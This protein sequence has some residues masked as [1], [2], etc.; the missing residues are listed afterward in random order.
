MTVATPLSGVEGTSIAI[1]QAIGAFDWQSVDLVHAEL[2]G[3]RLGSSWRCASCAR[4]IPT[5]R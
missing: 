5:C 2:G 1:K 4:P 3:G